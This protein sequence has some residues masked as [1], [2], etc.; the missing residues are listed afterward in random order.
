MADNVGSVQVK[1]IFND[2]QIVVNIL[3]QIIQ[4]IYRL[5][6]KIVLLLSNGS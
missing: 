1:S 4:I 2:G 3:R 6:N 5:I